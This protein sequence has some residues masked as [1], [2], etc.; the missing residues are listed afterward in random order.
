MS[1]GVHS[2]A[3]VRRSLL[4][5]ELLS[6]YSISGEVQGEHYNGQYVPL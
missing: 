6:M 4:N 3:D 1:L 2:G 5:L